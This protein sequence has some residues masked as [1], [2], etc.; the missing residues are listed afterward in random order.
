[1]FDNDPASPAIVDHFGD[2]VHL[3]PSQVKISEPQLRLD[4]TL[5]VDLA[6][7]FWTISDGAMESIW[8]GSTNSNI[9]AVPSL[10]ERLT[11]VYGNR[12]S[13]IRETR[14]SPIHGS[15]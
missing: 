2:L 14:R 11:S 9:G 1:M 10:F 3:L 12:T 4:L 15:G 5:L 8:H 7:M 6:I 13:T